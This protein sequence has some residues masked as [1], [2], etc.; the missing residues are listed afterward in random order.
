MSL[1]L[2]ALARPGS[3]A[4][5]GVRQPGAR[6][7]PYPLRKRTGWNVFF[8]LLSVAV[9]SGMATTLGWLVSQRDAPLETPVGTRES[10]SPLPALAASPPAVSHAPPDTP[11]P[12]LKM[13]KHIQ[14][15]DAL[16]KRL[17]GR[18]ASL[19]GADL[20]AL[21]LVS[22]TI[23]A[24]AQAVSM[25]DAGG[26]PAAHAMPPLDG[27][28]S[29]RAIPALPHGS[30]VVQEKAS[31]ESQAQATKE[32]HEAKIADRMRMFESAMA[33]HDWA[34]ASRHINDLNN[35]LPSDSLTLLR[36]RAWLL[37]NNG[38]DA[39][40]MDLYARILD[41]LPNDLNAQLNLAIIE[42]RRGN[43]S[44]AAQR[45]QRILADNPG[46]QDALAALDYLQALP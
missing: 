15:Q 16:I 28:F 39:E 12:L 9:L 43:R 17:E 3:M 11:A 35:L 30:F 2:E 18:L 27:A 24:P 6:H 45:L 22:A 26:I 33:R 23:Q 13:A 25:A 36:S 41:R 21:S 20:P 8:I 46:Q 7:T 34:A 1:I 32:D 38:G 42:T 10:T 44:S 37:M 5:P 4:P 29:A 14:E 40:S 31:M 19:H